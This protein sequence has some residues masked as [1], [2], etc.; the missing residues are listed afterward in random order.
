MRIVSDDGVGLEVRVQG[1]GPALMLVHGFGGAKEDFSDQLDDLA[2]DHQIGRA[3]C[4]ERVYSS[5]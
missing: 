4:R 1:S 2:R 5:V 3:S